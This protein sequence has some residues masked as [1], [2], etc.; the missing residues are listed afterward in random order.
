MGGIMMRVLT[1]TF[2]ASCVATTGFAQA[3]DLR[4]STKEV[5]DVNGACTVNEISYDIVFGGAADLTLTLPS[6]TAQM[7]FLETTSATTGTGPIILDTYE[8]SD[9]TAAIGLTLAND[10]TTP[11]RAKLDVGL[12]TMGGVCTPLS[13]VNQ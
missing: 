8:N 5:C 3:D 2:F 4:C 6:M 1:C 7:V 13:E 9:E 10:G 12:F 11:T